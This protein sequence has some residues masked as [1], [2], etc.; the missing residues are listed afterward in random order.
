MKELIF[1]LFLIPTLLLN[2]NQSFIKQKED[3]LNVL[4]QSK[5]DS[6]RIPILLALTWDCRNGAPEKSI[7]YGMEAIDLAIK[8]N[9]YVNLAKAYGFVGVA[10][11]VMGKYSESID[12]YYKGLETAEKDNIPEQAGFAH[13]NLANLYIYQEHPNLAFENIRKAEE[14]AKNEG[15]KSM[16]AYVY[17][18]YGRT[19]TLQNKLDTALIN[20]QKSLLLRQETNQVPEQATCYKYIGDIYFQKGDYANAKDN[21]NK[22]LEKVD[23][24]N[25]KD[26]Y[27]HILN[28][29][30]LILAR[31]GRL[32]EATNYAFESLKTAGQVRANMAIHDAL[33]ALVEIS[34]KSKDYKSASEFQQKVIQYND[35][36]FNQKLTEKIFS[37]EYQIEKQERNAKIELLNRDNA[38]KE[39]RL[40]KI[41]TV[42]IALTSVLTL[43]VSFLIILLVLIR[44]RRV[45][46]RLLEEQ[47]EEINMHRNS[48]EMQNLKLTEANEQLE[49]SEEELKRIVQTKDKLFSIIAHDLR[50][51][52]TSLV[53][54]TEIL[55]NST[56]R[57]D[58][59]EIAEFTKMIN[60]SSHKLLSLIEN[61]LQW[62]K[63]QTG[64]LK[65]NPVTFSVRSLTDEVLKIYSTQAG[66]KGITLRNAISE[67]LEVFADH[68]AVAIIMRNLVSNGIK[69]TGNGGSVTTEAYRQ[70]N[71]IIITI[72]DTGVGM[73]ADVVDKLFRIEESFTTPGTNAEGGT[74][75]GLIICREFA[76][77]SGGTIEIESTP[78]K[79]TTF[80]LSFPAG[81]K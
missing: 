45:H 36:L 18:F 77:I 6:A 13:L 74:G 30:S 10:Y 61:L 60:N 2:E 54:L 46:T 44:Q 11:R 19:Y 68:D 49:K 65:N 15:N 29:E 47:N 23:K 31:E 9:D 21:Y 43:L 52:F 51:P 35:T 41:K 56:E 38:I 20:Y 57:M 79:G 7:K 78:G 14:I 59:A 34:I 63:T 67:D 62:S 64:T 75:L 53:G 5:T 3:S 69:Y 16:L 33:Q 76:E 48:I 55:Y 24:Q 32:N 4:L 81:E 73:S 39:L 12:Y 58:K 8:Y 80:I 40:K 70:D 66:S 72:A 22:S 28:K 17:L 1:I 42:S 26:L 50:N 37:L 25:D 71:N 27:A